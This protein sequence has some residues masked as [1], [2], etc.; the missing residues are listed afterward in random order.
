MTTAKTF[1]RAAGADGVVAGTCRGPV[2]VKPPSGQVV[3]HNTAVGVA[4]SVVADSA[5]RSRFLP[6]RWAVW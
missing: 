3:E 1:K 5:Q 6:V 4:R 2:A